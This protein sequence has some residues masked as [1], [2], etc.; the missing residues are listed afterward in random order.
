MNWAVDQRGLSVSEWLLLALIML[1]PL[2]KPAI[3]YPVILADLAFLVLSAALAL[4]IAVRRRRLDWPAAFFVLLFYVVSL[5]PSLLATPDLGRSAFK[6]ATQVY[7]VGLSVVMIILV[8][9]EAMLKRVVLAWLVA[10]AALIVLA[11]AALIAF[12]I[13]PDGLIY[14]YSRFHFGTLPPG[15]YPRLALT[16]FNANMACNYLTVSLG[17]LFVAWRAGWLRP[18]QAWTFLGGIL[19]AAATTISPGLGGIALALGAGIWLLAGRRTALAAGAVAA[20]AFLFAAAFTPIIHPTAPFVIELAGFT[21][22]PSGRFLTWNAAF[23]EFGRHPIIG[24]GIGI[25]AVSVAYRD[26]SGNL[27]HLGDAHNMILNIAAQV[28]IV[29][30]AGLSALIVYAF[31]LA[32]SGPIAL[33]LGST[34]L[35][36]FVYHG[37]T[38]SFEDTR[39]L[40]LLFGLL[41]AAARLPV[42]RPDEN[43]RRAGGPSPC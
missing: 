39:H 2:M 38:G 1:V 15:E 36:A 25:E 7:L 14:A 37:L 23:G 10:T 16:F 3:A 29:G 19:V 4:E 17:L 11:I 32:R 41:V 28:G 43:N 9:N 20:L 33:G 8:R 24:H 35:I 34:F 26:P 42:S 6:L 13:A 27:Q 22:A 18:I 21:L 40:W 12:L 31:R 5:A 30:L